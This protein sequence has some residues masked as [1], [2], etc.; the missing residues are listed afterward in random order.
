M[1]ISGI[2]CAMR[3][4]LSPATRLVWQCLENHADA[5]TGAWAMTAGEIATELHLGRHAVNLAIRALEEGGI[6]R[7]DCGYRRRT[8]FHMLRT[9]PSENPS[10]QH[11][12]P[13]LVTRKESP[14]PA[15]V[16]TLFESPSPAEV[17]LFES[18]NPEEVTPNESSLTHPKRNPPSKASAPTASP[19]ARPDVLRDL[20]VEGLPILVDLTGM[21]EGRCRGMLGKLRKTA[22]DDCPRVLDA[23][24]RAADVCPSDPFPWLLNAVRRRT[25]AD[26][27]DPSRLTGWAG[28]AY[29][30]RAELAELEAAEAAG[31]S[32][33]ALE[34]VP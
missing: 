10:E 33:P 21:A 6:I 26:G 30:A 13:A 12:C 18:P 34:A 17:T 24:H 20:I 8:T 15:A 27:F 25:E 32:V 4:N 22:D 7:R 9:P 23:L 29:R 2:L 5:R 16:V 19:P 28:V 31:T 11:G 3:S 1:S 14:S